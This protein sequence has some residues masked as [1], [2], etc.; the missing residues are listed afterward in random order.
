MAG[1]EVTHVD[2]AK[3]IVVWARRNAELSSLAEAPIRWIAEDATKY[4]ER[5]LRRGNRYDAA[6]LDPP[7]YGHGVRGEVWRL[8]EDL[9]RLL[10]LSAELTDVQPGFVLLTC[11]TPG[12]SA[13]TLRKMVATAW[14]SLRSEQIEVGRLDLPSAT[15]RVLPSGEVVRAGGGRQLLLS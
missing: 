6:I 15:G 7:S 13:A 14:S 1:A 12:Y 3:N 8:A 4:V 2:A 9:P 10:S 11:H 5:E